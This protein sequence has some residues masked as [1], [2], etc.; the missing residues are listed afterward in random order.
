MA[1][2]QERISK[3]GY[4]YHKRMSERGKP[5]EGSWK[6]YYCVL[7]GVTLRFYRDVDAEKDPSY[8]AIPPSTLADPQSLSKAGFLDVAQC[9]L[10]IDYKTQSAASAVAGGERRYIFS[11]TCKDMSEYRLQAA[12]EPSV[13]KWVAKIQSNVEQHRRSLDANDEDEEEEER[14]RIDSLDNMIK[15]RVSAENKN[16]RASLR[17]RN[18]LSLVRT[19]TARHEHS[20]LA[21]I[22]E[23]SSGSSRSLLG[24]QQGSPTKKSNSTTPTSDS[25]ESESEK[26]KL[27]DQRL[28]CLHGQLSA[29][30]KLLEQLEHEEEQFLCRKAAKTDDKR[31]LNECVEAATSFK[32]CRFTTTIRQ[33]Y[34]LVP[35]YLSSAVSTGDE[36]TVFGRAKDG[37]WRCHFHRP[38]IAILRCASSGKPGFDIKAAKPPKSK[39]ESPEDS[40]VNDTCAQEDGKKLHPQRAAAVTNPSLSR[41]I[42]RA[43]EQPPDSPTKD[44]GGNWPAEM[45]ITTSA[46]TKEYPM[47][48]C[49]PTSLLQGLGDSK[50][51]MEEVAKWQAEKD[52]SSTLPPDIVS[53]RSNSSSDSLGESGTYKLLQRISTASGPASPDSAKSISLATV[54][55]CDKSPDKGISAVSRQSTA[56]RDINISNTVRQLGLE[57]RIGEEQSSDEGS[58]TEDEAFMVIEEEP[59]EMSPAKSKTEIPDVLTSP[60]SGADMRSSTPDPHAEGEENDDLAA[61]ADDSFDMC[62]PPSEPFGVS[63]SAPTTP[64]ALES[65]TVDG[66]FRSLPPSKIKSSHSR[67]KSRS[68]SIPTTPDENVGLLSRVTSFFSGKKYDSF[69]LPTSSPLSAPRKSGDKAERHRAPSTTSQMSVDGPNVADASS[70]ERRVSIASSVST[71][72]TVSTVQPPLNELRTVRVVGFQIQNPGLSLG[73]YELPEEA[74]ENGEE[75]ERQLDHQVFISSIEPRSCAEKAGMVVGDAVLEVDGS[76]TSGLLPD[77][78][79]NMELLLVNLSTCISLP[80]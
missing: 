77:D 28:L 19:P 18:V 62:L 13:L 4:M 2:A 75:E 51:L 26:V 25:T 27:P 54:L 55:P 29:R 12:N 38:G 61:E 11:L 32:R 30:Q 47:I 7:H 1:A 42:R 23:S 49:V 16:K 69:D 8:S 73:Q 15:S 68:K 34:Y 43:P 52:G 14:D 60:D 48:G 78:V 35:G 31:T 40:D 56:I 66:S 22:S 21:E 65:D 74:A 5:R 39:P 41:S 53:Q 72:T 63:A 58:D 33:E 46:T 17:T 67:K 9:L 50:Q 64:S 6:L 3:M 44:A 59:A 36:L 71:T 45:E 80:G 20:T 70:V 79:S 37:R 10:A 76:S 24:S 57:I